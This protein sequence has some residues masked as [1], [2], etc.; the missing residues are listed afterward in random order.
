VGFVLPADFLAVWCD[1]AL[2]GLVGTAPDAVAGV[3]ELVDCAD[4]TACWAVAA[5]ASKAPVLSTLVN[6]M[7]TSPWQ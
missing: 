4:A 2:I 6:L 3:G 5:K 1:F 7:E